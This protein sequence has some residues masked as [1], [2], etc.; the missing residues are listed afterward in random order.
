METRN[1]EAQRDSAVRAAPHGGSFF[2]DFEG[3]ST[4]GNP[5]LDGPNFGVLCTPH[6]GLPWASRTVS[7]FRNGKL[8]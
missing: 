5:Q 4:D 8:D 1:K 6:Y 2:T 7:T 3:L